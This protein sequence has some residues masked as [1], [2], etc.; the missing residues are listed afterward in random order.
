MGREEEREREGEGEG[1]EGKV[2]EEG[3]GEEGEGEGG[4]GQIMSLVV[5]EGREDHLLPAGMER[6]I[7][8][9]GGERGGEGEGEREGEGEEGKVDEEGEGEEGEGEGGLG[10][11][12]SLVVA[13]GRED[14]LLPAGMERDIVGK[15]GEREGE[16]EDEGEGEEEG[17]EGQEGEEGERKGEEVEEEEEGGVLKEQEGEREGENGTA[18]SGSEATADDCGVTDT[19]TETETAAEVESHSHVLEPQSSEPS[20]NVTI[21]MTLDPPSNPTTQSLSPSL[22]QETSLTVHPTVHTRSSLCLPSSRLSKFN[23]EMNMLDSLAAILDD[24]IKA[25][26]PREGSEGIRNRRTQSVH[27]RPTFSRPDKPEN[28]ISPQRR[29][30]LIDEAAKRI[31]LKRAQTV[32]LDDHSH[33]SLKGDRGTDLLSGARKEKLLN[34]ALATVRERRQTAHPQATPIE[35]GTREPTS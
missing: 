25:A 1:E 9:K 23:S 4:L 10:Q 15:G 35:E 18:I 34:Q 30:K 6:D 32:D 17:E 16:G 26:A 11:I 8:G 27:V 22:T 2:D 29:N 31:S 19:Q 14:H 7:V 5:A 21:E 24:T 20:P 33:P 3:E 12:M 13:E 28:L